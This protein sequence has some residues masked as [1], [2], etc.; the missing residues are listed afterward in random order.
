MGALI[1]KKV[2][3]RKLVNFCALRTK[4]WPNTTGFFA[5]PRTRDEISHTVTNTFLPLMPSFLGTDAG[6]EFVR[7][8]SLYI[9]PTAIFT[10]GHQI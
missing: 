7:S 8:W 9:D 4:Y 3:W 5:N 2:P 1:E 6:V 10:T